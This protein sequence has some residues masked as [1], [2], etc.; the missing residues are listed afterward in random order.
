MIKLTYMKDKLM[1]LAAVCI[2][3]S[4]F[5]VK[6]Y[7]EEDEADYKIVVS[8]GDSYSSGE[9]IEPFYGQDKPISERVKDQD[10]LAHRSE[11]SWPGR[12]E[13]PQG[14][15]SDETNKDIYWFFRATSGAVTRSIL[16]RV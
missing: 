16:D 11:N 1:I 9:G 4:L 13:F 7:A 15:L 12:L 3:I 10:W 8:L 6:T 2:L 5:P 14:V